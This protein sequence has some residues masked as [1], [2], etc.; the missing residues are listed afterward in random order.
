MTD[1]NVDELLD[2]GAYQQQVLMNYEDLLGT[3]L[4]FDNQD[5]REA[6]VVSSL[7]NCPF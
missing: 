5:F 4:V 1:K 6:K 3:E 2:L 7:E